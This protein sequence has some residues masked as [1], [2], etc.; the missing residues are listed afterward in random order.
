MEDCER[1]DTNF[2]QVENIFHIFVFLLISIIDTPFL[3]R[4]IL[5]LHYIKKLETS[6]KEGRKEDEKHKKS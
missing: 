4:L 1:Y 2:T 5:I 6:E 3:S